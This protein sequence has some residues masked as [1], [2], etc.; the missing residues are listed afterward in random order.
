ME[1]T[2]CNSPPTVR[3]AREVLA[4]NDSPFAPPFI[5]R[6][7]GSHAGRGL[8]KIEHESELPAY[9]QRVPDEQL[10]VTQ[11]VD[12]SGPDG[13]FRKFRIILVDGEPFPFHMAISKNWMV[14]YY[15]A[16]MADNAWMRAEE[17]H[18]LA[19]VETLFTVSHRQCL[20]DIARALQLE[21][22]GIDCAID[23]EGR[24]LVFEADPGVIVHISD[25]IELYPYKH[26]HVPR[27]FRAVE[28]M[29]DGR[30]AR[31]N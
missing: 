16:P 12:Y 9:L 6:P 22:V 25:P 13:H 2:G 24:I 18:F 19:S 26:Q 20:R 7:V 10:Y 28:R 14:H 8:E 3:L 27:I 17:E 15:N 30:I 11:Y 29:I 5:V 4:R 23:R 21:Y 1:S 31:S